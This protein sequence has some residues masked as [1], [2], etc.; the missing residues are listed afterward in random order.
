MTLPTTTKPSLSTVPDAK[1]ASAEPTATPMT[2]GTAHAR[3]TS[4]MTAPRS[5]CARNERT[6]VGMMMASDVPTQSWKI[7]ASDTPSAR[8]TS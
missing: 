1:A 3:T 2:A 7:T 8:K 4:I 5:R 6:L